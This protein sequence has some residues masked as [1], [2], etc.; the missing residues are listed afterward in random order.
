MMHF[1]SRAK[2][3]CLATVLGVLFGGALPSYANAR[4]YHPLFCHMG[5]S[6]LGWNGGD[7]ITNLTSSDEQ[8]YCPVM[9]DDHLSAS[10]VRARV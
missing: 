5:S 10:A 2:V 4:A 6:S 3:V 9:S 8:V 1:N 7:I